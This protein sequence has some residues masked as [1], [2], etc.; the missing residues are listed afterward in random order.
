MKQQFFII[1][2]CFA[3]FEDIQFGFKLGSYK[4]D[5]RFYCHGWL[6]VFFTMQRNFMHKLGVILKI[7]K[8]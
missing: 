5:K 6:L 4:H 1:I 8:D 7:A 3:L 2:I